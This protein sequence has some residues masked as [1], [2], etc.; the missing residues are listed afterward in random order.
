MKQDLDENLSCTP[1]AKTRR[2]RLAD[3][4][5]LKAQITALAKDAEE[6]AKEDR[7]EAESLRDPVREAALLRAADLAEHHARKL[8]GILE[9]VTSGEE[10]ANALRTAG[11]R[12]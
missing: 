4:A 7:K 6:N 3:P 8:R 5:W 10:L 2:A 11:R 9:G 1:N 12:R